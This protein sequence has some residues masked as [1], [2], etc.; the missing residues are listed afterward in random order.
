MA[1]STRARDAHATIPSSTMRR[2][3]WY[4]RGGMVVPGK[5]EKRGG[6]FV[7]PRR[8]RT[9]SPP[10]AGEGMR[11]TAIRSPSSRLFPRDRQVEIASTAI[12]RIATTRAS[13]ML[14]E[15]GGRRTGD[16]RPPPPGPE[17][18]NP[19]RC[20]VL[21]HRGRKKRGRRRSRMPIMAMA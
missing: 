7:P 13:T 5:E 17:L 15:W 4:R 9:P 2:R 20:P 3:R 10:M 14:W 19:R 11:R 8:R 12:L 6:G 18:T 1:R 16:R 21:C